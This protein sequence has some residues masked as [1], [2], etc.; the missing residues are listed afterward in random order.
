MSRYV[1]RELTK[2]GILPRPIRKYPEGAT[3]KRC[4]HC[5][6]DLPLT[7][8]SPLKGGALGVNPKCK[9]CIRQIGKDYTRRQR[10][11]KA[12]R[13]RP[14][15]CE[16]CGEPNRRQRALHWDHNHA[17]GAFRGWLCHDCNAALGNVQDSMSKLQALIHY[18]QKHQ[19][20]L[21]PLPPSESK[22]IPFRN[23]G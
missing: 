21:E 19:P 8:F 16:C 13:P 12:T 4:T 2:L 10:E 3:I 18:L 5:R 9:A 11:G 6:A 22:I 20:R 1:E 7:D 23:A 15:T 17:T 14:A